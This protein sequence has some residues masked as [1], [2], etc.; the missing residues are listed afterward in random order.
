MSVA[1]AALA[2]ALLAPPIALGERQAL[3]GT[4]SEQAPSTCEGDA[5]RWGPSYY[6]AG[7]VR[8]VPGPQIDAA[9]H[10]APL[11]GRPAVVLGAPLD[12]PPPA[13]GGRCELAQA[14]SDWVPGKNGW[15]VQRLPTPSV[16]F[17]VDAVHPLGPELLSA[18]RVSPAG[19]PDTDDVIE[20]RLVNPLDRPLTGLELTVHHEGCY[21]KPGST[22]RS[23]PSWALDPGDAWTVRLP[24]YVAE[25]RPRGRWHAAAA[26]TLKLHYDARIVSDLDVPLSAL[27]VAVEC[28]DPRAPA[29]DDGA[30]AIEAPPQQKKGPAR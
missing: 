9:K 30:E 15:R 11:A 4:I 23:V 18:K 6:E 7:F 13:R 12:G 2:V 14:R 3:L 17:R 26:I 27:G 16:A 22:A 24:A 10:L 29:A 25:A 20:I 8:L 1:F 21:G 5:T 28:P 19:G